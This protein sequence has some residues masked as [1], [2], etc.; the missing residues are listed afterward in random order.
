MKIHWMTLVTAWVQTILFAIVVG[1]L[2]LK[3]TAVTVTCTVICASNWL[4]AILDLHR[5]RGRRGV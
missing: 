1:C 2:T 4:M 5:E 3:P